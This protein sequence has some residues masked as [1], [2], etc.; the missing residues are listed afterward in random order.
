MLHRRG[1]LLIVKTSNF[2]DSSA[3]ISCTGKSATPINIEHIAKAQKTDICIMNISMPN[4]F[5]LFLRHGIQFHFKQ[6]VVAANIGL[7]CNARKFFKPAV[8]FNV[9]ERFKEGLFF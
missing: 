8:N 7:D 3:I 1:I 4:L 5:F 6:E 9:V 2:S